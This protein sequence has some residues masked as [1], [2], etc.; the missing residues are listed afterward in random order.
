M[1]IGPTKEGT[2]SPIFQDR[3]QKMG[4]WLKVNGEGVYSTVPWRAQQDSVDKNVWFTAK[5]SDVDAP[6]YAFIL[7]WPATGNKLV[8][9]EPVSTA[10]SQ[11]SMLGLDNSL[12]FEQLDSGKLE[13]ELP[14]VTGDSKLT[15]AW[16]LKLTGFK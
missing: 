3:L 10:A 1:N 2:I 9:G 4:A 13:I 15:W 8:L 14:D 7:K 5:S 11:V 12:M 16:V 6:V